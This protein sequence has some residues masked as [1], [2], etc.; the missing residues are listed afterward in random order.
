MKRAQFGGRS[1]AGALEIR[2]RSETDSDAATVFWSQAQGIEKDC[3]R[4]EAPARELDGR[5]G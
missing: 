4:K 3:G 5:Q 2:R 1:F